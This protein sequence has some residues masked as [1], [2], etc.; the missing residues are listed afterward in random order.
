[1]EGAQR[2]EP[3]PKEPAIAHRYSVLTLGR[4]WRVVNAAMTAINSHSVREIASECAALKPHAFVI[5]MGNNEIVGPY[6]PSTVFG[7]FS[8]NLAL[9]RAQLWAT[10]LRAGQLF[11]V[12]RVGVM[13]PR[14]E[15][16]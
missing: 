5:Y 12:G 11:T 4:D 13:T 6:G 9:I 7:A 2:Y 3:N 15:K 16:R 14:R 8:G 1:V 10:S